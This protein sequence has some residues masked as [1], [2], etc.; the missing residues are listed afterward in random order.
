VLG[1][2][3]PVLRGRMV[4]GPG[5]RHVW[6]EMAPLDAGDAEPFEQARLVRFVNAGTEAAISAAAQRARGAQTAG[7]ADVVHRAA[8]RI[9]GF[10]A[11]D[12]QAADALLAQDGAQG[13]SGLA[14]RI[15]LRM[16]QR[17][18]CAVPDGPALVAE[19]EDLVQ[20]ALRLDQ[21][22]TLVLSAAANACLKV[23]D[24]PDEALALARRALDAGWSNPFAHDIAANALLLRGE[25]EAAWRAA[26]R[27]RFIGQATPMAHFFDMG[28]CLAAVAT[29]RT[30]EALS[31]ARQAAALAPH[32]RPPL[33]YLAI[34]NARAVARLR[35]IEPGFEP[36]RMVEDPSYPV[37]AFRRSPIADRPVLRDLR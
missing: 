17:V 30:D 7:G 36:Q 16:V 14:W 18:E 5:A 24:R 6:A 28:L 34:L 25:A 4:A 21:T 37:A 13:A 12:L 32:F 29:G 27:A 11:A 8:R 20:R 35:E 19:V 33:R 23:L 9:F 3:R 22:N 2:T 31:L 1:G 26:G 10:S 15:F